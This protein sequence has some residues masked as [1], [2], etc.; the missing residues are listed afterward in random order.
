MPFFRVLT[1]LSYICSPIVEDWVN[2][3]ATLLEQRVDTTRTPHIT[4]ANEVL[5]TE[6]ET[7]FQSTWKDTTRT[8]SMYDQLMKLQM[9][10][11]NVNTYNTMFERLATAA[12]WEADAKG[13]IARYH[14]GLRENIHQQIINRENL[15]TT[16]DKW[17]TA[18]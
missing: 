12:E 1:A 16:M 3:Q 14:T 5:W 13:T 18:V 2:N 11:L 17:K 15:P 10:D 8:Q 6:F 9:K 7:A 4:E